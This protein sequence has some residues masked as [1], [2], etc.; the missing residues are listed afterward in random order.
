MNQSF[1]LSPFY[2]VEFGIY[3]KQFSFL[4]VLST[5]ILFIPLTPSKDSILSNGGYQVN[6]TLNKNKSNNLKKKKILNDDVSPKIN[7]IL[8][9]KHKFFTQFTF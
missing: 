7:S 2:F 6:P 1:Y 5:I 9:C 3:L 8:A 4:M